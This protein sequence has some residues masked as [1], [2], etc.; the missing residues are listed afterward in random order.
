MDSEEVGGDTSDPV[1]GR[2]VGGVS[3]VFGS[4]DPDLVSEE[5]G[6]SVVLA[7]FLDTSVSVARGAGVRLVEALRLCVIVILPSF[8]SSANLRY[9][10]GEE[11]V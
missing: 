2:G 9:P 1:E 5:T 8:R 7:F 4:F 10:L 3:L 11:N 6:S